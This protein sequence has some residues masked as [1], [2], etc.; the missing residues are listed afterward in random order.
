MEHLTHAKQEIFDLYIRLIHQQEQQETV[1]KERISAEMK[2]M[3]REFGAEMRLNMSDI[4]TISCIGDHEPINVTSISEKM[5]FSKAT[6]SR[7]TAKLT[8]KGLVSKTQ[9]SDNKKEI[10]FRLSHKGRS[11]H[12]LHQREHDKIEQ[13][14]K[15]FLSR[16]SS[17][18]ILFA[19]ALFRDLLTADFL[20]DTEKT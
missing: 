13:R 15:R 8:E 17:D 5:E 7:I 3:E 19:R 20:A 4:H 12:H 1:M 6:V 10:Y 16:Y 2:K 9:L 14:F 18:E 11:I